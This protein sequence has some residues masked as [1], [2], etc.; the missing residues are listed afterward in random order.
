MLMEENK[1]VREE[2]RNKDRELKSLQSKSNEKVNQIELQNRKLE[3][4]F[5]E[6]Q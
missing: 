1:T 3:G 5:K 2:L 6:K 4:S